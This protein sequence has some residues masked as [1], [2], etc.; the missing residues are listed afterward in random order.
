MTQFPKTSLR[1]L[2]KAIVLFAVFN[3]AF[4]L[5]PNS[6]LWQFSLYNTLLPGQTRFPLEN[7]LN[8]MFNTH[9]ISG[10]P[11]RQNEYKVVVL[12]DSS[13]WGFYLDP[14]ETFSSNINASAGSICGGRSLHLYNLGYP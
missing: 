6:V 14:A 5:V 2:I 3:Y 9:E 11:G 13:V 1:I 4:V 8:L 12:G 7:D 10:A